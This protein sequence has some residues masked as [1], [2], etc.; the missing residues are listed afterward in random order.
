MTTKTIL[1]VTT[2]YD[3]TADLVIEKI[4]E[5]GVPFFRLDTDLFPQEVTAVFDP[6]GNTFFRWQD[7]QIHTGRIHSVWHRRLT[8]PILPDAIS[9]HH[10][11]FCERETRAFLDG[12]L[13]TIKTRRWLSQPAA[14][15]KAE[16]KIYQLQVARELGFKLPATVVTNDPKSAEHFARNRDSIVKA[17]RSGYIASPEGNQAI[18]TS[19]LLPQNLQDLTSLNLSPV[20][21]QEE[22]KKK[23]DI[24]VTIIGNDL[25]AAEIL[26]QDDP[27]S[28]TDWRATD[29]PDLKHR[30][31]KLP[32]SIEGLC[33]AIVSK[34]GLQFAS[35]DLALTPEDDYVFFELNPN[36]QW[37]WLEYQLDF[38]ISQKIAEWL[39]NGL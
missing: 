5:T 27:S 9:T 19:R 23:S 24:R 30:V 6:H 28:R 22:I 2:T 35:I 39:T 3:E 34:M 10:R 25:F 1:V 37:L 4:K 33:H 18:F 16:R 21:F 7:S 36:G 14:L 26:S 20:I 13:S 29:D 17:V 15:Q 32:P 11:E 12:V 38:P 31:H 8:T